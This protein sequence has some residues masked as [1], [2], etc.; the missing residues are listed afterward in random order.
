MKDN[1]MNLKLGGFVSSSL[2]RNH[3]LIIDAI[4]G[5]L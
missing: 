5:R 2:R 4:L 1:D 3:N